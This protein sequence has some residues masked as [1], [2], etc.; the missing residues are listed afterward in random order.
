MKTLWNDG[1]LFSKTSALTDENDWG[2]DY[3]PVQIPHDWLIYNTEG[4]YET[5]HGRYIKRFDFGKIAGRSI[6]LY[7]DGVYMDCSVFVN[8]RK[9]FDWKYGYS[10][11]EVD[12]TAALCDGENEIGVLV[13]HHSPNTRFYSG[14]GIFRNVWLID[15][16]L[17]YLVTDGVY[18][19]AKNSGDDMSRWHIKACAEIQ[20][21]QGCKATLSLVGKRISYSQTVLASELTGWEFELSDVREDELWDISHPELLRLC[22]TLIK[23]G[24]EIDSQECRVGLRTI[25]YTT[26]NGFFLNGK[27]IKLN[28][29]CLHHDL[30]CLGS[31]FNKEAARRQLVKM[32]EMGANSVRTAHNMPAKEYMELCD[33]LGILV[34]SDAFDIWERPKTE[35]DYARFFPQWYE[36]DVASWIRRDRNHPSIIMWSMGN[37]I[38]D[39]HVSE[40][41]IEVTRLL[42]EAVRKHDFWCNA[43]TTLASNYIE[44]ENAQ[45]CAEITDIVGYNYGERLYDTHHEKYPHWKIYG[46]ENTSGVKS[47]GVYHFPVESAF[48]TH[49]DLQCSALGNCRSGVSAETAQKIIAISRDTD[50][51]AGLYIWTGIDYIGE[52][53]PYST[54]NAYFGNV[55]TAGLEKDSFYLYKCAWTDE[56]TLHIM[57]YWDFNDGQLIDV[58]CYT[59][60]PLAELF[61]NGVSQGVK[62]PTEYTACW[63]VPYEK[64]EIKVVATD[65]NG[66]TLE[67]TEHSFG[68]SQSLCLSCDKESVFA[69]GE[70]LF[71]VTVYAKDS[72]GFEV[73]NARDR[74]DI[75]VEGARLV[76]FDNGDSTD[77][78]GYKQASRRLFS[79]KAVAYFAT[80]TKAGPITVTACAEGLRS[81]SVTLRGVEAT[82]R[83]GISVTEN[84]LPVA[85]RREIPVRKLELKRSGSYLLTPKKPCSEVEVTILPANATY[86]DIEFAVVTNSGVVTNL[87]DVERDGN[88]V[89]VKPVGDG[90]FRLRAFC[91]NGK[92]QPEVISE[93]EYTAEGF[94][95]AA[96]N[97][98]E[99]VVGC[100]HTYSLSV[101]DEVR[102][103]GVGI[104]PDNNIV[105]FDKVDFGQLGSDS[106]DI[107]IIN[108][109]K[110]CPFGFRLWD[111]NPQEDGA[112]LLGSFTYQAN[113]I[114]QTYIRNSYTLGEKLCGVHN[115]YFEFDKTD[116]RID[117]GGFE[118]LPRQKAY[119]KLFPTQ[120]DVLHGDSFVIEGTSVNRIGNNVFLRFDDMDF[121]RGTSAVMLC[122][123]THHDNDSV[124]VVLAT[125][126]GKEITQIVEFPHTDEVTS[127]IVPISDVRGNCSVHFKFLPGCDFDFE[128]FTILPHDK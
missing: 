16:P 93:L 9:I 5:S 81:A 32:L 41:G 121:T 102:E 103:G 48:L 82:A 63:K 10:A 3:S 38:Y 35:Y 114:W 69:N 75:S 99:L 110:D 20:N 73:K 74:V 13:R 77:Y 34:N 95:Q 68:D 21:P 86:S 116:L 88:K 19:S 33:E 29:V 57:P 46:S 71:T 92:P 117:F 62:K 53:T 118:F 104:K 31:A 91:R 47:R 123:K 44:W 18:F 37:E 124:H 120:S 12:L 107:K 106:F 50:F 78:D 14:A 58:V 40:R 90:S 87:A 72:E 6:R 89:T 59:S 26:D 61:V 39:T 25:E 43:P 83:K 113:F 27:N 101:M 96:I 70:D 36:K 79:G 4:L 56:P 119:E 84:I 127:V 115:L 22:V 11:F 30:G 42:H 15:T 98:Y 85:H 55:D 23:N 65:E 105:G 49:D 80:T 17:S 8:R 126:D 60:Y 111:N 51:C 108:W 54:K 45:R 125:D 2:T 94:G 128:S 122:G 24:E 64:G 7:F 112:R 67:R 52:P 109:H 76:G 1:F 100:L 97:P 28:G 66:N